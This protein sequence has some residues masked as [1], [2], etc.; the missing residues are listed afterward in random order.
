MVSFQ[1]EVVR[2]DEGLVCRS[3]VCCIA[4]TIAKKKKSLPYPLAVD[5]TGRLLLEEAADFLDFCAARLAVEQ[6]VAQLARVGLHIDGALDGSRVALEDQDL[7]LGPAFLLNGVHF[8]GRIVSCFF[9]NSGVS[10]RGDCGLVATGCSAQQLLALFH[11]ATGCLGRRAVV[12]VVVRSACNMEG[13]R[14]LMT[15]RRRR[16]RRRDQMNGKGEIG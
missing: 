15:G 12:V 7:V 13:I 1:K 14:G 16:R 11:K 3:F 8:E 9:D 10:D 5:V 2:R 6:E 4:Y